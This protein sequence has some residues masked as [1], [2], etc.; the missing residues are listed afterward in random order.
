M[1]YPSTKPYKCCQQQYQQCNEMSTTPAM[2]CSANNNNNNNSN[3][4]NAI[5][6][7]KYAAK[8]HSNALRAAIIRI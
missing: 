5:K 1:T 6:G 3:N 7:N 8:L 2:Q 4:I